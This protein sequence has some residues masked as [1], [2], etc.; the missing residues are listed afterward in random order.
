VIALA[1]HPTGQADRFADKFGAGRGAGVRAEGVH[2][3]GHG[4]A[5][6]YIWVG[7]LILLAH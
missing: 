4:G 1:M 2:G 7:Q 6:R 3:I 5:L